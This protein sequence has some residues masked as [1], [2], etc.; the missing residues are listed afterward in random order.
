MPLSKTDGNAILISNARVHNLKNVSIAIPRDRFIVITGL[1]GSGKSSL[2]FDTIYAEGQRRYV[3]S[4][5]AYARQFLGRMNK[6]EVDYIKG[7]PPAIAVEQKVNTR[8]PRS[9]VGTSTEIYD[10]LKLLFARIG[11]TFSPVSGNPVRKNNVS[12]V[13]DYISSNRKGTRLLILAPLNAGSRLDLSQ[14]LEDLSYQGI[15]R[16]ESDGEV[17]RI[18]DFENYRDKIDPEQ[19]RIVIDRVTASTDE[20][21]VAR[22]ADSVQMAFRL[23]AGVCI[24]KAADGKELHE[25]TFSNSFELDGIHF[26]EPTV[27]MFSFNNPVGACPLCEGYGR[28]IGIDPDLVIPDKGLSIYED[29]IACWR[30]E[31]MK[32]WKEKLIYNAEKFGFPIH[33]PYFQLSDEQKQLLWTGNKTFKGLNAFFKYL[34][35]KKYKI[36]YRVMLARYRGKT[37][38]TECNG[39]RLKKEASYV[40]V[41]NKN[42]QQ[43]VSTPVDEL[44][45]FFKKLKLNKHE[46]KIADRI[47]LELNTRLEYLCNVGLSYLTL[48][49]LS[50]TLSGGESQRI[51]LATTLGSS[52]VGSLYILDE[53]SIGLHPRD[54]HLLIDVLQQLKK[55]GNT[56][57][58]VEHE[59][60]I[61]RS[62]DEIIDIGPFA[63]RLGGEI[64]FQ[65]TLK[66]LLKNS[67]GLTSKYLNGI[68]H[69]TV[70]SHRR[71]WNNFVEFTGARHNNLKNID[72]KIPLNVMTVISGVSGS[73]KSSLVKNIIYPALNKIYNGTGEK[74]GEFG[75]V[76]GDLK[77]LTDVKLIDQNPIGKSSRS[78]PVTY[79]KAYDEIRKL[80]ADQPQ[81]KF[82]GFKP[83]HFSFNVDGGRCSECQGEGEV[84]VEMQFMADVHLVCDSCNG[85]RFKDEILDVRYHDKNIYDILEC[86]V[87]EAIDFFMQH[88]NST[89]K[90]IVKKLKP[91]ADV[92]LGY[93]KLGQ[94]S[95]T[96]SGGESQRVK[97]AS[98]LAQENSASTT[99]FIFDEPTT[100][101]HF[102][103]IKILLK[104]LNELIDKGHSVLIVE[105]NVEMIKSADW[106]IDLGPE[107][108][109]NGGH[110]VYQGI[111]EGITNCPESYTGKFLK[112]KLQ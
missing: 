39:T 27:H 78:N 4:L 19:L 108:G 66:D 28:I 63:G 68:E 22:Y 58:V 18:S 10:Y 57:M 65:G 93:V 69:I 33:K 46:S 83:S 55:I 59:E 111:P 6:P 84:K 99:L 112:A 98:F 106:L 29:A 7:I 47:L 3:E 45:A 100:G 67:K 48:N 102:H 20:D 54:T 76:R 8:N 79:I 62:A 60:E 2:A 13:V 15:T 31:K 75:L 109:I 16:I 107:G 17:I 77:S 1:S 85:R 97:L 26:E 51:N 71:N 11:K 87:N 95:S 40:K 21:S 61:I 25:K 92:G 35:S 34:E 5:S 24:I 37:I 82:N 103:D 14:Q 9:T 86:T 81:S 88:K 30:G 96:L 72:V 80:M 23:G 42:I 101:L 104:A 70:P 74:T 49:R 52:L 90:N 38:C 12:D 73:G 53:P 50:S 94:S 56:V 43:L 105:H 41:G 44:R 32:K 64:I 91:L 36:Q 110:I 89:A